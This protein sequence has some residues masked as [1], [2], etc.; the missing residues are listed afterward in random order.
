MYA[1]GIKNSAIRCGS[2]GMVKLN[3]ASQRKIMEQTEQ[4][5]R[6]NDAVYIVR[7][8]TQKMCEMLHDKLVR[9]VAKA[10]DKIK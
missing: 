6:L 8:F 2:D 10:G 5:R 3:S 7:D 4:L 9:Y 1:I